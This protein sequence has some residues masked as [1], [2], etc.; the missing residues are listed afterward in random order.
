MTD[1]GVFHYIFKNGVTHDVTADDFDGVY[2]INK[3]LSY[4]PKVSLYLRK[5]EKERA[6]ERELVF[7]LV[8]KHFHVCKL[9]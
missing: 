3:W 1:E 8:L 4:M 9:R 7:F 5:R 6:R 2:K